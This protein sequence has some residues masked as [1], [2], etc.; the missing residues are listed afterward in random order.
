[1]VICKIRGS[2]F[3]FILVLSMIVKVVSRVSVLELKKFVVISRV[4]VDDCS[5]SVVEKLSEKEE[6]WCLVNVL[7]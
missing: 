6:W 3:E 7:K 2:K 5:I 1:M 4:V